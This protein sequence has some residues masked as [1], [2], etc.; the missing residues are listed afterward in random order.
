MVARSYTVLPPIVDIRFQILFHS[1][2]GVLFTFPSRYLFTIGHQGVFSLTQWS[3]Q[4]PTEFH[5]L[6]GTWDESAYT[7]LTCQLRGSHALWPP[8]PGMFNY[9][10]RASQDSHLLNA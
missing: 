9:V 2:S 10:N 1:P 4:I 8:V 5:V 3:G 6:Y 7:K